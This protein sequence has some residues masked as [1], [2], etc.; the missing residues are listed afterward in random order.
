MVKPKQLG[1]LV[2]RV[3]DLERSEKFYTSVLGLEVTNKRPGRMVFMSAGGDSSH[4]LALIPVAADAPAR[5]AFL[6]A[7]IRLKNRQVPGAPLRWCRRRPYGGAGGSPR[8]QRRAR[9]HHHE[10]AQAEQVVRGRAW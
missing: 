4:E 6:E 9:G 2:I 8:H 10:A 1:H 3:R 5:D 7:L